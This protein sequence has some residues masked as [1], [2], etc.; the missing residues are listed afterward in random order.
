MHLAPA[1]RELSGDWS[2]ELTRPALAVP[3]QGTEPRR[4]Q[5]RGPTGSSAPTGAAVRTVR[6]LTYAVVSVNA[7]EEHRVDRRVLGSP[8][9][10]EVVRHLGEGLVVVVGE[11][12]AEHS[13][14]LR[15]ARDVLEPE[16]GGVILTRG[17]K[18]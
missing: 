7:V 11:T 13:Q 1:A 18:P 6:W 14:P 12:P 4:W 10:P 8:V 9:P 15:E 16:Q 5:G 17:K 2:V 3:R